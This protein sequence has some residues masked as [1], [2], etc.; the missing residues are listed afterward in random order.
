MSFSHFYF[1]GKFGF[2]SQLDPVSMIIGVILIGLAIF[3]VFSLVDWVREL[4]FRKLKVKSR[5]ANFE[6]NLYLK[7]NNYLNSNS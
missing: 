4:L 5:L 6:E 7:F 2:L 1:D 3:V